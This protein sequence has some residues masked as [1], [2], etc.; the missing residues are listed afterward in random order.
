VEDERGL[1]F[2]ASEVDAATTVVL[3]WGWQNGDVRIQTAD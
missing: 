2:F 1:L 3:K